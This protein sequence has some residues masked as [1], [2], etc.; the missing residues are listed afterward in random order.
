MKKI[1]R[2]NEYNT[3]T[4][5]LIKKYTVSYYGDPAGYEEILFQTEKGLYFLYTNGGEA[6]P[7]KAEGIKSVSKEKA[8]EWL[9]AH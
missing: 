9:A 7:Y 1:I 4:A 6:S 8:K 2:N 5:A 3:E